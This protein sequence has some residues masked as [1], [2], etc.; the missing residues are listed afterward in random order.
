M[1]HVCRSLFTGQSRTKHCFY[2]IINQGSHLCT[3][4]LWSHLHPW[5]VC[6]YV[7][8][9]GAPISFSLFHFLD[10]T[11]FSFTF[12]F[13]VW[14]KFVC[15]LRPQFLSRWLYWNTCQMSNRMKLMHQTVWFDAKWVKTEVTISKAA[16]YLFHPQFTCRSKCASWV[17]KKQKG[18]LMLPAFLSTWIM[19][20]QVLSIWITLFCTLPM[21][22]LGHSEQLRKLKNLRAI[23][24]R[25]CFECVYNVMGILQ[26]W[27]ALWANQSDKPSMTSAFKRAC[28]F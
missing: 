10:F 4:A 1:Y 21:Q 12:Y 25:E 15:Q 14:E 9:N 2:K 6:W 24:F 23:E 8:L 16:E 13:L 11:L 18:P 5:R 20:R 19:G 22:T 7:R 28:L 3:L 17:R 27:Q 26:N